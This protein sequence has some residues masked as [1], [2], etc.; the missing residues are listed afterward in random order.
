MHDIIMAAEQMAVETE[1][2]YDGDLRLALQ[3]VC[4]QHATTKHKLEQ[5][6]A[7]IEAKAA[8]KQ[9]GRNGDASNG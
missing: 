1:L 6:V 7:K 9:N 5:L 2:R 8:E 3:D 4:F